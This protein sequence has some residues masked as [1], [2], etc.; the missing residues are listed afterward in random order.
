MLYSLTGFKIFLESKDQT[1]LMSMWRTFEDA[2]LD[3]YLGITLIDQD[4]KRHFKFLINDGLASLESFSQFNEI[5][6]SFV[7]TDI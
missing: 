6:Y 4:E 1:V 7:S 5:D 3:A 2:N